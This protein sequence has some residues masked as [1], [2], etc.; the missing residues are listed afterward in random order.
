MAASTVVIANT[1]PL[2]NFAEIGRLELLRDLFGDITMP[3]AVAEEL[4]LKAELF[5]LAALACQATFIKVRSPAN[6]A[7]V[8]AL[9]HELHL[10]EAECIALAQEEL[11]AL[12]ILDD[13]AA[14]T[15]SQRQNFRLTGTIGC[16]QLAK[17]R[18]LI[19]RIGPLLSELRDKARFWLSPRLIERVLEDAHESSAE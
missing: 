16:L 13:V 11:T 5:P 10:G 1:T 19:P 2:I 8:I 7:A 14:R 17:R 18:G 4:R 3:T 12:L 6:P 9:Q 15:V